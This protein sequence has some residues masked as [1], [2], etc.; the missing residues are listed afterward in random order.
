MKST[1]KPTV[2]IALVGARQISALNALAIVLSLASLAGADSPVPSQETAGCYVPV[3]GG[4]QI[5]ISSDPAAPRLK[6]GAAIGVVVDDPRTHRRPLYPPADR[7][8]ERP[9]HFPATDGGQV[10]PNIEA[11]VLA[12]KSHAAVGQQNLH[13]A[14]VAASRSGRRVTV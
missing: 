1:V 14:G 6:P 4:W 13:A 7:S 10:A 2:R 8:L 9:G 11:D 5:R 12:H 3:E